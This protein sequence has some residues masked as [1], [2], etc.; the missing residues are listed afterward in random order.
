MKKSLS[1]HVFYILLFILL[2]VEGWGIPGGRSASL[3]LFLFAPV[4]L[5]TCQA[6]TGKTLVKIPKQIALWIVLFIVAIFACT[7]FSINIQRAFEHRL[8][9]V[10]LFLLCLFI[11]NNQKAIS[12]DFPLFLAIST[13]STALYTIFVRFFL[14]P[15]LYFLK[16]PAP[17]QFV[18]SLPEKGH[19]SLGALMLIPLSFLAV[20]VLYK[21]NL[22]RI[23]ATCVLSGVLLLSFLRSGYVALLT[24]LAFSGRQALTHNKLVIFI[25]GVI[26]SVSIVVLSSTPMH[27]L[28]MPSI[29]HWLLEEMH[30]S[31]KKS[32]L[33]MRLE[34]IDQAIAS[35]SD[36]PIT[37]IGSFNYYYASMQHAS[38]IANL[39]GS[40]HN[41]FLDAAVENGIPA[42]L[43]LLAAL[44]LLLRGA[45]RTHTAGTLLQKG[46]FAVFVALVMLFQLSHYHKMFFLLALCFGAGALVYNEKQETGAPLQW[47]L[48]MAGILAVFNIHIITAKVAL[49]NNQP[50]T[51]LAMYPIYGP[52][53]QAAAVEAYSNNNRATATAYLEQYG[54]L[55]DRDPF[56]QEYIGFMYD[57]MSD[58]ERALEYTQK[59]LSLSPLDLIYLI[60]VFELMEQ[61][62]GMEQATQF[63][64]GHI[65]S[66]A[67]IENNQGHDDVE[68]F[69]EW[70]EQRKLQ[71]NTNIDRGQ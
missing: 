10:S 56:V 58:K 54:R 4:I 14:P 57:S 30:F 9:Y 21:P 45:Y 60:H 41:I 27:F 6:F 59:A 25:T 36:H 22:L 26:F 67:L 8:L 18:Y 44:I 53:Y 61:V 11:Y 49:V 66:H 69:L 68:F 2:I 50:R 63:L 51:A 1:S 24:V 47:L 55:Y 35:I 38:H 64:Y 5:F 17:F 33:N 15:S 46:I 13:I 3:H 43:F 29:H 71:C 40:S 37:G 12:K 39:T 16:S 20:Q 28:G 31:D 7:V 48:I 19:D 52:A 65:S 32:T 34:L 70:C 42:A 62:Q 23:L